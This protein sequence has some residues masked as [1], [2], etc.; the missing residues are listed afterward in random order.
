MLSILSLHQA[1]AS[2]AMALGRFLAIRCP[3]AR[4]FNPLS[5][6]RCAWNADPVPVE[7]SVRAVVRSQHE[8]QGIRSSASSTSSSSCRHITITMRIVICVIRCSPFGSSSTRS[9]RMRLTPPNWSCQRCQSID[10]GTEAAA[11][12]PQESLCGVNPSPQPFQEQCAH[13]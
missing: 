6:A 1:P 3:L 2:Y 8:V 5:R 11:K 7:V 9:M 13:S 10:L 4:R 12:R